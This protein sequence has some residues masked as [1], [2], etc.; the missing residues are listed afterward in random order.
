MPEE[1]L[2]KDWT[3]DCY[4]ASMAWIAAVEEPDW[5]VVHGTV[6]SNAVGKRINHA[7]CERGGLVVDLAMPI[8]ARITERETYYRVIKVE[9]SKVYSSD[10][11]LIVSIKTGHNGPWDES[12]QL[13]E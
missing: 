11:A 3:G 4:G 1:L 5:L 10:D 9:I 8:G 12:E 13:K 6:W 7:W 2:I